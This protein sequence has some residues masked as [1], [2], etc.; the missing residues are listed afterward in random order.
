MVQTNIESDGALSQ[1]IH[2]SQ[3]QL[4]AQEKL[5]QSL[6][7]FAEKALGDLHRAHEEG[8]SLMGGLL[9]RAQATVH[10]LMGDFIV[11]INRLKEDTGTLATVSS[12]LASRYRCILMASQDVEAATNAAQD[13]RAEIAEMFENAAHGSTQLAITAAHQLQI[14][15]A[16]ELAARATSEHI[17]V[18]EAVMSDFHAR[19]VRHPI[20]IDI[21][22]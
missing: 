5:A 14:L 21:Q 18:L 8:Q 16:G 19:L 20:Q 12:V 2:V 1:A 10:G 3:D 11:A 22:S 9:S 17:H 15:Q 13:T 7:L 6:S 4:L